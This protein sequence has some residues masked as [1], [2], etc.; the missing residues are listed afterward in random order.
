MFPGTYA[1][2]LLQATLPHVHKMRSASRELDASAE[3]QC[4]NTQLGCL[5]SRLHWQWCLVCCDVHSMLQEV[6]S[7]VAPVKMT[8]SA[9]K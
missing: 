1:Y 2:A 3:R 9:Y 5:P 7:Y 4:Q 6:Q 8:V